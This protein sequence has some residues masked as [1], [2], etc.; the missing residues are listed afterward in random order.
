M[1]TFRYV[2]TTPHGQQIQVGIGESDML[3]VP[4]PRPVGEEEFARAINKKFATLHDLERAIE[5]P[6]G[7]FTRV[8]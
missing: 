6:G 4:I 7:T 2:V 1:A 8:L 5:G 3:A